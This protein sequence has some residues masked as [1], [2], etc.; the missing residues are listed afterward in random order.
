MR[1]Q[2][3][4]VVYVLAMIAVVVCVDVFFLR[5]QF[6]PRLIVNIAIVLAFG[7]FYLWFLKRT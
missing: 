7:A 6:W 1:S 2:P 3:A 4:I 5:H